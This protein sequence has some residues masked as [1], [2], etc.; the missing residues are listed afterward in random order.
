MSMTWVSSPWTICRAYSS[1]TT[2]FPSVCLSSFL[3]AAMPSS[4]CS[5]ASRRIWSMSCLCVSS[6]LPIASDG[7]PPSAVT[8]SPA[9][10]A[11]ASASVAWLRIHETIG[12]RACPK[13]ISE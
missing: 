2:L 1:R 12:M 10:T 11:W 13:I 5:R 4:S 9:V 3:Y 6:S 7:C 8:Y